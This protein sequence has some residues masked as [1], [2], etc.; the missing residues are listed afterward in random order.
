[1]STN[2]PTSWRLPFNLTGKVD[3]E[4][5]NAIRAAF[6]GLKDLNDAVRALTPKVNSNTA[7]IAG[8][9]T[10]LVPTSSTTPTTFSGLGN[11]NL[12][13]IAAEITYALQ[14]SDFGGLVLIQSGPGFTVSLDSGLMA[15]YFTTIHDLGTGTVTLAPTTGTL[16]NAASLTLLT[17]EGAVVYFDGANWWAFIFP[18]PALSEP[19]VVHNWLDSFNAATGVFTQSQPHASDLADSTVGSGPVVLDSGATL[20]GCTMI[21]PTIQNVQVFANNAAAVAG[22]LAV[23]DL[24]RTGADPDFLCTVH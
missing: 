1:M 11:V 7:A 22:G 10:A 17:N 13:P 16:N 12:L 8:M 20:I 9:T 19:K 15:P 21:A 14:T 3:P 6:N 4:A 18:P 5:E 2:L 23:G 24:Y